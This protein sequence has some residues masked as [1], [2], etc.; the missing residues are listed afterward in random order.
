MKYSSGG[1]FSWSSLS[2][3]Q[4]E[5]IRYIYTRFVPVRCHGSKKLV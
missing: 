4:F 3:K 1:T 5:R 2:Y